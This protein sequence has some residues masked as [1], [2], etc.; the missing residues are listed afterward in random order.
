VVLLVIFL[1]RKEKTPR[2]LCKIHKWSKRGEYPNCY[3]F[4][5]N[6]GLIPSE[7]LDKEIF[8]E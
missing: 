5:E 8:I 2:T 4:C 3:I 7:D 6:C 1:N